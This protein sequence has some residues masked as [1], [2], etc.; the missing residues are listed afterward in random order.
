MP[1]VS[2][3]RA[4]NVPVERIWDFVQDMDNWAP[5]MTGYQSH[6]VKND[7]ESIWTLRGDVGILSR[8]VQLAVTITEWTGP[9]RVSFT[10]EGINEMVTGDGSFE[11]RSLEDEA[12][13]VP[14]VVE[15]KPG[16]FSRLIRWIFRSLF[17]RKYGR[18]EA[19][20][21]NEDE[22]C[23]ELVF[24]WRMEAG[25]PTAPLVNAMLGPA[26]EP[27][28]QHLADQIARHVEGVDQPTPTP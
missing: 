6:E 15:E 27:A 28:A 18:L 2:Y 16:P 20:P 19:P 3:R 24:T 17:Q 22:A 12:A 11:I 1:E 25:G 14:A 7:T 23:S 9:N 21:A 26:I 13:Q 5:M 10:L 4:V 8:V